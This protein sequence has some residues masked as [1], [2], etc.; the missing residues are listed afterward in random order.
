MTSRV[1]FNDGNSGMRQVAI[2][3]LRERTAAQANHE[4]MARRGQE[5]QECHHL[6]RIGRNRRMR[7][8]PG[9]SSSACCDGEEE[10]ARLAVIDDERTAQRSLAQL[11]ELRAAESG[12][13]SNIRTV[14]GSSARGSVISIKGGLES[15][16]RV[17]VTHRTLRRSCT[18][19]EQCMITSL[20]FPAQIDRACRAQELFTCC[21]GDSWRQAGV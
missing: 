14:P 3:E 6:A 4:H 21:R 8:R 20:S 7:I 15:S 12:G 18:G 19:R 10:A 11:L 17:A 5:Q 2:A 1:D 9:A 13:G 16:G